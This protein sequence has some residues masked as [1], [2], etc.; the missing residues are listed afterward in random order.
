MPNYDFKLEEI[1][2]SMKIENNSLSK[3]ETASVLNGNILEKKQDDSLE[4]RNLVQARNTFNNYPIT[5]EIVKA[6]H[7]Y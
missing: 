5:E 6:I 2:S 4:T 1:Y 7:L 3:W